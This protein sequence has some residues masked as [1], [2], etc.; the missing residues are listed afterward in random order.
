MIGNEETV[1]EWCQ[2]IHLRRV[3][4]CDQ[5]GRA[6]LTTLAAVTQRRCFVATHGERGAD[7]VRQA[8]KENFG[9]E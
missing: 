9:C 3:K 1:S 2:A 8:V 7:C 6:R 4:S 5:A